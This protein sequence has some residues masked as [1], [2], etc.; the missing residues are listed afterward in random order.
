MS[1]ATDMGLRR[2]RKRAGALKSLGTVA[3]LGWRYMFWLLDLPYLVLCL[4]RVSFP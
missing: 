2:S 3:T 4:C 1:Y